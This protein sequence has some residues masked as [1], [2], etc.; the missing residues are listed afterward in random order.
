MKY[1]LF[2]KKL[3]D[4]NNLYIIIECQGESAAPPHQISI[5]DGGRVPKF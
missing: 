2:L 1:K 3:I 4:N 5:K